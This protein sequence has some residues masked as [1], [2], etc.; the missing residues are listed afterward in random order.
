M[1]NPVIGVDEVGLGAW[2]GPLVVCAFAAPNLEWNEPGLN[3]SKK[4]DKYPRWALGKNLI[5]MYEDQYEIVWVSAE[6]IDRMGIAKALPW[7]TN[8]AVEKLIARIGMPD[9]VILDGK[10]SGPSP[11][12][13][14]ERYPQAD[15]KYTPVMAAS[16]IAK[17]TRDEHMAFWAREHPNYGF[18]QHVGYGT[19]MHREAIQL[20]GLLPLHRRSY[21][22][23][24]E[25]LEIHPEPSRKKVRTLCPPHL[26]LVISN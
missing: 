13:G 9:R 1:S 14:A 20:H 12:L 7:A 17:V 11:V 8:E 10:D 25:Y 26:S 2:A 5:K 6:E 3:D 4:L 22:P 15:G 18:D 21:R 23:I 19:D 16:V 24:R